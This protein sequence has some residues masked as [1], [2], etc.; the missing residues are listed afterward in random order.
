MQP[1]ISCNRFVHQ[2]ILFLCV[3]CCAFT[4]RRRREIIGIAVLLVEGKKNPCLSSF[5]PSFFP[6]LPQGWGHA[7]HHVCGPR[8][9]AEYLLHAGERMNRRWPNVIIKNQAPK[10]W[11]SI[12]RTGPAVK[13]GS[14]ICVWILA[15]GLIQVHK[16]TEHEGALGPCVQPVLWTVAAATYVKVRVAGWHPG[17]C[18]AAVQSCQP[19]LSWR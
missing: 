2:D 11:V 15:V 3:C 18:P 9:S 17:M 10:R 16:E 14:S 4:P 19:A 6:S 1:P 8:L 13:S 7:F 5:F 12:H